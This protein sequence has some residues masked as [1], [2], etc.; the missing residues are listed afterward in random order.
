[1]ANEK[2]ISTQQD[3]N[4]SIIE[5][6]DSSYALPE[7]ARGEL[8]AW[9]LAK[10]LKKYRQMKK[11]KGGEEWRDMP[12][13]ARDFHSSLPGGGTKVDEA[14]NADVVAFEGDAGPE[15][16]FVERE[17]PEVGD[18]EFEDFDGVPVC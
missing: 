14:A 16:A 4:N 5:A 1:M 3:E 11:L 12:G 9:L 18:T 17:T 13:V 6:S 2:D 15:V 10:R 8:H 7:S